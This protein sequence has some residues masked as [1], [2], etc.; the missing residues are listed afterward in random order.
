[1]SWKCN[2]CGKEFQEK[3]LEHGRKRFLA[4]RTWWKYVPCDGTVVHVSKPY[5]SLK[6]S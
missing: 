1:M 2:K 4:L 3:P 6:E 5:Y